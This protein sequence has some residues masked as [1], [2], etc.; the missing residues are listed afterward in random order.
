MVTWPK[1][2]AATIAAN[3]STSQPCPGHRQQP[4]HQQRADRQEHPP[5]GRAIDQAADGELGG[6]TAQ[7]CRKCRQ[8]DQRQ[9]L[10]VGAHSLLDQLWQQQRK[11]VEHQ[12]T[13]HRDNQ[14]HD[15][16]PAH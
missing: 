5:Q 2:A 7:H 6:C 12:P 13:H 1:I 11:G 3:G 16:R 14:Q 9:Q 10:W 15:D 4:R 8:T